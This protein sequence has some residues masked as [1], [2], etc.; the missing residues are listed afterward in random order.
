MSFLKRIKTWLDRTADSVEDKVDELSKDERVRDNIDRVKEQ[1]SELSDRL[2]DI[3]E[4]TGEYLEDLK[5]R[6]EK[7]Y[8]ELKQ[9]ERFREA[10]DDI[11]K[12]IKDLDDDLEEMTDKM[13]RK[14]NQER[15]EDADDTTGATSSDSTTNRGNHEE[16]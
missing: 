2:E 8:E 5:D 7:K 15:N 1:Y 9:N 16:E 10:V 14:F 12:G 4:K 13:R 6:G 3:G 11:K